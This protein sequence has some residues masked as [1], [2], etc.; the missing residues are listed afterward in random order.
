[1]QILYHIQALNVLVPRLLFTLNMGALFCKF[2]GLLIIA[3]IFLNGLYVLVK[4][5]MMGERVKINQI[6]SMWFVNTI[7]HQRTELYNTVFLQKSK[8]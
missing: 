7:Q 8:V 2:L 3:S 4:V 1:M 5:F 6:F